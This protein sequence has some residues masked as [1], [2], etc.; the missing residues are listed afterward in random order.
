VGDLDRRLATATSLF[1]TGRVSIGRAAE[2]G[3]VSVAAL[4]LHLSRMGIPVVTG[5]STETEADLQTL[6]AWLTS[7]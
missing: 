5:T 1:E 4:I 7:D 6:A 3:G 2:V